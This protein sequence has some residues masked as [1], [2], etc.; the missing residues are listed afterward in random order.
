MD[1]ATADLVIFLLATF[2]AALVAGL[3][4]FAFGLVAAAVW[5]H[6]LTPLQTA[7]LIIAFG[8]I[9]QGVAVWKLRHALRWQRLWPFL[10]GGIVGVPIGVA[11]LGW[12]NP[13]YM[14]AT[15]GAV[16]ILYSLY[17]F[18]RPTMPPIVAGGTPADTGI[19]LLNGILGG[20]TGLAGII[21]TIWCGL[22]G[23]PKDVQRTVFQ[24]I[25]VAIFALSAVTL[26]VSGAVNA[27]TVRLFI[28]GLPILLAGTWLGLKLYGRVD[29]AGFRKIVLAVLLVSGLGLVV[30]AKQVALA[31][32]GLR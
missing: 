10:I 20:A 29:D 5:L 6:I 15:V 21:V 19:G 1:A 23:W 18:A 17:G 32:W 7:S 30:S 26:G 3:A 9:V 27:E 11:V 16:L 24:P 25:G 31:Q 14:R 28:I 2:A 12:A 8:L 13:D 4:G 22:R